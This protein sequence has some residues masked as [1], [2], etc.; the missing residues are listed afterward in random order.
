[1]LLEEV[2]LLLLEVLHLDA[3]QAHADGCR[4]AHGCGF[5]HGRFELGA[6]REDLLGGRLLGLPPRLVELERGVFGLHADDRLPNR[7]LLLVLQL[8]LLQLQLGLLELLLVA[9]EELVGL[10]PRPRSS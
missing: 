5:H 9:P 1:M 8:G 6:Q 2:Q 4:L 3:Q 7:L 10:R